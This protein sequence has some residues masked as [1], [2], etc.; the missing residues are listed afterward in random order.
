MPEINYN[1]IKT[2]MI[3]RY[4]YFYN[5]CDHFKIPYPNYLKNN[6]DE[7]INLYYIKYFDKFTIKL[8]NGELRCISKKNDELINY[9][10]N[11]FHFSQ[12]YFM[13]VN[14][15]SF[16]Y[17]FNFDPLTETSFDD[18]YIN[19]FSKEIEIIIRM[20]YYIIN[21]RIVS[22]CQNYCN[23]FINTDVNEYNEEI[24]K[25]TTPI[26]QSYIN[27]CGNEINKI[28]RAIIA[29]ELYEYFSHNIYFILNNN[30]FMKTVINK[31]DSM[32]DDVNNCI[33]QLLIFNDRTLHDDNVVITDINIIKIE[34]SIYYDTI[35]STQKLKTLIIYNPLYVPI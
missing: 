2:Y 25:N 11:S 9:P 13:R 18:N 31:M 24:K 35:V 33:R 29:T 12:L 14:F 17:R 10:I 19:Q 23:D 3:I 30:N 6:Y 5:L 28:K 7:S 34:R 22:K 20:I 15:E 4:T 8:I 21:H 27:N 1:N 32:K 16:N 26:I